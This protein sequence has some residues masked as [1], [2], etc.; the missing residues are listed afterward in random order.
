[1]SD[2]KLNSETV[3]AWLLHH[4]QKLASSQTTEFETI[5]LAGRAARLLSAVS[6]EVEWEVPMARVNE[7]ARANGIRAHEVAG[8]LGALKSQGLVD[9]ATD[10]IS[11]LGVSQVRHRPLA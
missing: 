6:R 11:V 7:L 2:E 3:G 10:S 4:D 1:M 9:V 8:L 5:A